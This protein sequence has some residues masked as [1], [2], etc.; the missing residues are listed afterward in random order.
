MRVALGC[1]RMDPLPDDPPPLE[2]A[3]RPLEGHGLLWLKVDSSTS[4]ASK[5]SADIELIARVV[6]GA[7]PRL[8][9]GIQCNRV[10]AEDFPLFF[11]DKELCEL[12]AGEAVC[13]D[14]KDVEEA[15]VVLSDVVE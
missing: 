15:T 4:A 3:A 7:F 12:H 9:M 6:D 13:D 11:L 14:D 5:D 10:L 8:H 2:D 1:V